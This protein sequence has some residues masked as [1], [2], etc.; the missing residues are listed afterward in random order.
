MDAVS[1]QSGPEHEIPEDVASA[2][3]AVLIDI[4]EKLEG[5]Q[6]SSQ[7]IENTDTNAETEIGSS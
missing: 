4:N 6:V 2:W 1:E 5:E 3:A 7:Q